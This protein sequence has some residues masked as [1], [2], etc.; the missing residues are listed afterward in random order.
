ML[1]RG[2]EEVRFERS[3][4][5][6]APTSVNGVQPSHLDEGELALGLGDESLKL[7]VGEGD[8]VNVS[9]VGICRLQAPLQPRLP[10]WH[11]CPS[12]MRPVETL[13]AP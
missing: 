4:T 10:R 8:G 3:P 11:A 2:A 6:L 12:H 7:S 1:S 13:S 9:V 5:R